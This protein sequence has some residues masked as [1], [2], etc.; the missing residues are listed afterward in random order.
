MATNNNNGTITV[1]SGDTLWAIATKYYKTYGYSNV[2]DYLDYLININN[3]EN[4]NVILVGDVLK[5]TGSATSGGVKNTTSKSSKMVTITRF[6]LISNNSDTLY[7]AWK[8]DKADKTEKYIVRWYRSWD[9]KGIAPYVD[10]EVTQPYDS[11]SPPSEVVNSAN[12][13][14]SVCIKP[15]A[16]TYKV[17]NSDG[18][19]RDVAYFTAGF[20]TITDN[21]VYY[22]GK[23]AP[24][25]TPSAPSVEIKDATLTATLD[26]VPD[27]YPRVEFEVR[28][29]ASS[30]DA[31]SAWKTAVRNVI[32]NTASYTVAIDLGHSYKVRCRYVNDHGSGEWSGWSGE[33]GTKPS[34]SSEITNCRAVTKTEV[35]LEWAAVKNADT[36]DI[37]Y[38]TNKIYF[39]T[40]TDYD[41]SSDVRIIS[42]I[43]GTKYFATGLET[44]D[45]YFFRVR[46]VNANGESGWSS[47]VS[48]VI[49]TK[50]TTPSTWSST[51]TVV[52]GEDVTFY[53]QHNS[54]DGSKQTKAE[55]E[56]TYNGKTTVH[57]IDT[58][59][60]E[61]DDDEE[62][63]MHH[64]LS[65]GGASE[66]AIILWRV[67]TAGATG[68]Y[69]DWSIQR[70][71]T[72]YAQPTL[73]IDIPSFLTSFP[74]NI[75]GYAGPSSQKPVSYHISIVSNDYY[76]I[77]DEIGND[78]VVSAGDEIFS[79][80][81]DTSDQL[82]ESLSAQDL[83]LHN[84]VI[85]TVTVIVSMDSGL[86]AEDTRTF[87][88][89]W[90][91]ELYEPNA[92]VSY[93]SSTYAML[94]RPYCTD[95]E[96]NLLNDVLLSVY[97]REYNGKFTEI[98]SGLDNRVQ[99]YV[100]DPHP[101]LDYARYRIVAKSADT[102]SVTYTDLPAY[103]IG[104]SAIIIQ[105]D[106]VWRTFDSTDEIAAA[107]AWSGSLLRLLYNIDVSE[108]FNIDASLVEYI[109][110][111]HPVSY[112]GTQR[113]ESATWNVEIPKSDKE[114]LYG[115]R[116]L[117]TW[118]GNVY[119]REPSGVG[120]WARVKPSFSQ[121]HLA[122]VI[123]ITLNITR[124]EG[125][126]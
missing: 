95:K 65:T 124:V 57:T 102:G 6:G 87:A 25:D 46:A 39:D 3:I 54:E 74:L 21:L 38:T 110:R 15:V 4:R 44:G 121:K 17:T 108:D 80:Y 92:E 61:G 66:G 106:D 113:G 35:Y 98:I 93:D 118:M 73:S 26:D 29:T 126:A 105:W 67:R 70:T 76:E 7:V 100:T 40:S 53:W 119:V 30:N 62:K 43:K 88:V 47:Y 27:N 89:S 33:S 78:V 11:Y 9:L 117:A 103:H 28:K 115:L 109:G 18:S 111:E 86:T 125:G 1:V 45:E 83:E 116:R 122:L 69:S 22:Y 32:A 8:W 85:Y 112:Y 63:L 12:G 94:I 51:T 24:T 52:I 20:S 34:A 36:Y 48:V 41:T 104:E 56:I 23:R 123:P 37:A 10:Q 120:Y 19:E 50:P 97:R 49:G 72:I 55:L 81:I 13:K 71:V 90:T 91:D 14:V 59:D 96:G 107:P 60:V 101:A 99:T 16:K 84:N 42:A 75:Y 5:V 31:L 114:T 58:P 64:T 82:Y 68:E 79:K 77:F 2:S